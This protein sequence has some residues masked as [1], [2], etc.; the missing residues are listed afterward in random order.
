MQMRFL[1]GK[2]GTGGKAVQ[3][4][5]GADADAAVTPDSGKTDSGS[6]GGAPVDSGKTD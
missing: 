2:G 4:D 5:A 6:G 3:H 1:I